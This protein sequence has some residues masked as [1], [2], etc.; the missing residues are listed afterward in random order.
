M[1]IDTHPTPFCTDLAHDSLDAHSALHLAPPERQRAVRVVRHL[2][3]LAA[4]EVG[5]PHKA[6]LIEALCRPV[7]VTSG[8]Q[9]QD[10]RRGGVGLVCTVVD[11]AESEMKRQGKATNSILVFWTT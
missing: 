2:L 6:S 1:P 5:V 3:R 10:R 11:A 8:A 7:Y 9:K 4:L